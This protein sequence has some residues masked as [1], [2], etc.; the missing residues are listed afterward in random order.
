MKY[1][2]IRLSQSQDHTQTFD[3]RFKLLE[4]TFTK[5]WIECVLEA[6]Q[7]QYK[8]SEP[9][10]LYNINNRLSDD[11]II[12]RLNELMSSVDSVEMLFGFRLE[13]I[14]DQDKLNQIHAIF[15]KH[16]GQL[17]TWQ[18]NP[19]FSNKENSFR[20]NLSEINQLVHACEGRHG[21]PK[22]RVVWFDLPKVKVFSESDYKLFTDRR[23]FGSLYHLYTDVGKNIE[24][25]AIDNDTHHHDVVP[26]LHFSADC[27]AYFY[28]DGEE[29]LKEK[30]EKIKKYLMNNRYYLQSKG[31]ALDDPRLTTGRIELGRLEEFNEKELM[32]KMKNYDNIQ[33]FFLS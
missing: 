7:K 19:I 1:A 22:I 6:Q 12:D 15:E 13:D 9:W 3:L 5:K 29:D 23:S 8:I 33:S 32:T 18:K 10:A 31:Y 2:T 30:K 21:A 24:S 20:Q 26:N 16:H 14:K 27:V 4:N 25:L 17:D 11:Y 28:N